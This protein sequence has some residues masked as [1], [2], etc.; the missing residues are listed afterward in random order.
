MSSGDV[1]LAIRGNLW[2]ITIHSTTIWNYDSAEKMDIWP[3]PEVMA[4]AVLPQLHD[5]NS[6]IC[7]SAYSY[8]Y[9]SA[10]PP[11]SMSFWLS[12]IVAFISTE[13][14][15]T[16]TARSDRIAIIKWCSNVTFH[17]MNSLF[18]DQ[19]SGSICSHRSN[20]ICRGIRQLKW[21]KKWYECGILHREWMKKN[22]VK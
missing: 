18:S 9:R 6:G 8:D 11:R 1:N 16:T 10:T 2:L 22:L 7:Q 15:L 12:Y 17:F 3:I 21:K 14:G 20:T 13:T 5:K 4:I 19:N